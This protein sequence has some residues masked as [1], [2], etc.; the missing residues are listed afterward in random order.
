MIAFLEILITFA[1]LLALCLFVHAKMG[2]SGG[3]APLWVLCGTM[4]WYSVLGSVHLLLPAGFLWFLAARAAAVWLWL[5]RK[6]LA[7]RDIFSPALVYFVLASLAVF[8]VFAV[9]QPVFNEWD[10][11][12]F[13]G[14]AAKVVKTENQLYTYNPGGMR[15]TTF[16]PGLIMLDYAFQF[17]GSAFVPWKGYAAY[18]VR[19]FAVFAAAFSMLRRKQWY[20]AAPAAAVL[21]LTPFLLT[22]YYRDVYVRVIYI[23]AYADIPMGLLFGAGLVLY[24]APRKKTPAVV[25]GALLAI[26]ATCIVKD[27]GFALCLIAAAI[28]CFDLLFLEK[29]DVPFFRLKGLWGRLC[30]CASLV[31]APVAAFLGWAAHMAAV[32]EMNRFDVGGAETMGMVQMVVTGLRELVGIGRTEKF[33][34]IMQS[35]WQALYT[36][37]M[38]MFSLGGQDTRIG[39]LLNG[40]GV[41]AIT[42]I[43]VIFLAAFLLG[44][45]RMKIRTA[46]VSLWSTL[47][48]AAFYIFTGFTYVYVFKGSFGYELGDYTRYIYPY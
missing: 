42:L 28:V 48:F 11:F 31:A 26:T 23:N 5:H 16:V 32:M 2:V 39:S 35:M 44:D 19:Y 17:L 25:F 8:A 47:G 9:R 15:A 10:E 40:S 30:W 20:L 34:Q 37:R 7:P 1:A 29:E 45:R 43:L 12:S 46:W 21:T 18:D 13:W 22:V 38:T 6:T 3:A 14:I 4:V 27:M 33:T 36:A 24:F 41:I